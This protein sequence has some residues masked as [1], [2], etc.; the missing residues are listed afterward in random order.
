MDY[1]ITEVG[2]ARFIERLSTCGSQGTSKVT[3]DARVRWTLQ[4]PEPCHC[5][6]LRQQTMAH[7]MAK[8]LLLS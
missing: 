5:A 6:A 2:R 4:T 3:D 8:R 7:C 1:Q